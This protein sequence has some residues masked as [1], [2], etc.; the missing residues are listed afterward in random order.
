MGIVLDVGGAGGIVRQVR[1]REHHD[2]DVAAEGRRKRNLNL[3]CPL[4]QP[5]RSPQLGSTETLSR[6]DLNDVYSNLPAASLS[7]SASVL[8][9]S[10]ST[11]AAFTLSTSA[12]QLGL[13]RA[14][15]TVTQVTASNLRWADGDG[16]GF[17]VPEDDPADQNCAM[18]NGE[19]GNNPC[20]EVRRD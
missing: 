17:C 13:V 1:A 7:V 16:R 2:D 8:C 6:G 4:T 9:G 12:A 20:P 3:T 18:S 5:L 15:H 10:S 11:P 14:G 19:G